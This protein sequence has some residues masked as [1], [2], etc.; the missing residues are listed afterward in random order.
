[1]DGW[2][3]ISVAVLTHRD[4][5]AMQLRDDKPNISSPGQWGLFGGSAEAGEDPHTAIEREI[6]EE[7]GLRGL[8]FREAFE[9]RW[10]DH[11]FWKQDV[12]VTVFEAE[13]PDWP[14]PRLDEGREARLFDRGELAE[15]DPMAMLARKVFDQWQPV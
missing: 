3:P 12:L 13:L 14:P 6:E 5:V 11:P 15:V 4:R 8:D 10:P 7:L 2:K 9:I 1:M